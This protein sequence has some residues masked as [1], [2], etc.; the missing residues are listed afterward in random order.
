M[1]YRRL[2]ANDDYTVGNGGLSFHVNSPDAVGQAVLTRLRL[3]LGEWFLDVTEGTPYHPDILGEHTQPTYDLA[4]RNRISTTDGVTSIV[5]YSSNLDTTTRA[6][7]VNA[8]IDTVYGQTE[9][10]SFL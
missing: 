5:S 10:E 4:I 7:K 1:R 3:L 6:L 9:I 2:D 8:T